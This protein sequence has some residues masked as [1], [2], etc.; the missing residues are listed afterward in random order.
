[1][2]GEDA[3]EVLA[4]DGARR[5]KAGLV[6]PRWQGRLDLMNAFGAILC[7]LHWVTRNSRSYAV[8]LF[9][10]MANG[11]S[12]NSKMMRVLGRQSSK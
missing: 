10:S 11:H 7:F 4:E 1:M 8:E 9:K 5:I 12:S 6:K 3:H 2:A